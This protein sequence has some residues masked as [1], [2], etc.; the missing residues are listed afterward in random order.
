VLQRCVGAILAPRLTWALDTLD[1]GGFAWVRQRFAWADIEPTPGDFRWESWDAIVAGAAARDLRLL[2]VLDAAPD[3]AGTPPEP[4]D[5]AAFAA[6]FAARYGDT[7]TYYQIWHNPNLGDSWGGY[8]NAENYAALLS[9]A[10]TAIRAA[11]PDARI[12]LGSLA[13]NQE[14]AS[15]TTPKTCS[16]NGCI[17]LGRNPIST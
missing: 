15:A 3:W 5:F 1:A 8:A 9:A 17:L 13:P 12:V 11:D 16:W 7:L 4:A 2:A 14:R 10:A 6:A